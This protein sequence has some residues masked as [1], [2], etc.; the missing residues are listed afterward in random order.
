MTCFIDWVHPQSDIPIAILDIPIVILD[1][2]IV[3]PDIPIVIPDISIVILKTSSTSIIFTT[4]V[5]EVTGP[6]VFG[7]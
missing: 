6:T 1:I 3:I 7:F 4:Q 5:C 2:P